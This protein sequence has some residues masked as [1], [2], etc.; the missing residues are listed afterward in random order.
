MI[1]RICAKSGLPDAHEKTKDGLPK[2]VEG[3]NYINISQIPAYC[4]RI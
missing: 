2:I 4:F 1:E 3:I